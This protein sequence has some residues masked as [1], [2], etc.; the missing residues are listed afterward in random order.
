MQH[1]LSRRGGVRIIFVIASSSDGEPTAGASGQL[2]GEMEEQERMIKQQTK[3]TSQEHRDL[4]SIVSLR[5]EGGI[6]I[7]KREFIIKN[8]AR[9]FRSF[10]TIQSES[11]EE[12]NICTVLTTCREGRYIQQ[13]MGQSG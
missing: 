10:S 3:H 11:C 5:K 12:I 8:K 1:R 7:V 13:S 6:I 2:Q 4:S 9:F